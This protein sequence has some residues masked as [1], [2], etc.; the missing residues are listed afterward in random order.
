MEESK[1]LKVIDGETLLDMELVAPRFELMNDDRHIQGL[2]V[3]NVY[4]N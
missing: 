3:A 4:D 1:K 2:R